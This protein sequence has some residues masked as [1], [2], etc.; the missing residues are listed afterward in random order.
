MTDCRLK[1]GETPFFLFAR[2][3]KYARCYKIVAKN[4]AG[5]AIVIVRSRGG[6]RARHVF[7][8]TQ[9]EIKFPNFVSVILC[10]STEVVRSK[11]FLGHFERHIVLTATG[12]ATTAITSQQ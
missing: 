9:A 3:R 4:Y 10:R 7:Y 11:L 6:E 1:Q 2:S 5:S 12:L 8:I